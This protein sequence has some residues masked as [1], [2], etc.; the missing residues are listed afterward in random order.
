MNEYNVS[1]TVPSDRSIL[2]DVHGSTGTSRFANFRSIAEL[3]TF[4]EGVGLHDEKVAEIEATCGSLR[5]GEAYH[6]KMFLPE[7]VIHAF[8]KRVAQPHDITEAPRITGEP[9]FAAA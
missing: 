9:R 2:L 3:Q 1:F 8:E 7:A 6:E 5:P 4:F